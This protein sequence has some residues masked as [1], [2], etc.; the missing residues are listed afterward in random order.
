MNTTFINDNTT[1][2]RC[3]IAVQN[4]TTGGSVTY[5]LDGSGTITNGLTST[6]IGNYAF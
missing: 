6:T 1:A 4:E 3:A 5:T 2:N